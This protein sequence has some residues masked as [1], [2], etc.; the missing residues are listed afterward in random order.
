MFLQ[1]T[2]TVYVCSCKSAIVYICS[3]K[4]V[5]VY[6]VKSVIVYAFPGKFVIVYAC[7]ETEEKNLLSFLSCHKSATCLNEPPTA[8]DRFVC[9]S[10][11][12]CHTFMNNDKNHNHKYYPFIKRLL[13]KCWWSCVPIPCGL[14]FDIFNL[15]EVLYFSCATWS[16]G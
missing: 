4:P 1:V 14:I 16:V 2:V 15:N 8:T 3:C 10:T 6:F 11:F 13:N 12:L 7:L 5:I 9:V